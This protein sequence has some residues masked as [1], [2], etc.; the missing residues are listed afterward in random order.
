MA[1]VRVR[2][3][4]A[5]ALAA[6]IALNLGGWESIVN[7]NPAALNGF[8]VSGDIGQRPGAAG[9]FYH[10]WNDGPQEKN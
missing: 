2:A 4:L 7:V 6:A 10:R 3:E 8:P 1:R 5:D 9:P